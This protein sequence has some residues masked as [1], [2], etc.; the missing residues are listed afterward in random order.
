MRV[1]RSR[2]ELEMM[3]Q[4]IPGYRRPRAELEQY[5]TDASLVADIVWDAY[6]RGYLS[7]KIIDLGCGTGRFALATALM[8]AD[9]VLCVDIDSDALGIARE[10]SVRLG[11]HNV[12]FAA[13]DV[14]SMALAYQFHVAFQNPPF[15]IWARRGIDMAFLRKALEVSRIVYTMHKLE[16]MDYVSRSVNLWGF[17][18]DL[19]GT[20]RITIP[21]TYNHHTRAR[22][23]VGVF[24]ARITRNAH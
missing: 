17:R 11:L 3:I 19:L 22:Y 10:N 6:M 1:P 13:C 14:E 5:V 8:G 16:T 21:R 20:A 2:R 4:G 24:V 9:Y 7:G 18:I 23:F 15:G 12:D